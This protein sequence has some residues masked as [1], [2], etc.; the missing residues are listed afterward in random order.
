MEKKREKRE[1][2][3]Y[4][5]NCLLYVHAVA[6][7]CSAEDIKTRGVEWVAYPVGADGWGFIE[8]RTAMGK[9]KADWL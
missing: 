4:N 1:K 3:K 8:R 5:S 7:L 6:L 2:E 9:V